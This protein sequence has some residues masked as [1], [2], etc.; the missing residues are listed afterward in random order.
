MKYVNNRWEQEFN[1]SAFYPNAPASA[2][3]VRSVANERETDFQKYTVE[4]FYRSAR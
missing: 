4:G 3:P 1:T 2:L